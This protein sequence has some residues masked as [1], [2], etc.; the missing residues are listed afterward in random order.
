MTSQTAEVIALPSRRFPQ[1]LRSPAKR[2]TRSKARGQAGFQTGANFDQRQRSTRTFAKSARTFGGRPR[3]QRATGARGWNFDDA[4][5]WAQMYAAPEGLSHS[6]V[7]TADRN[8]MV[9]S[10]RAAVVR[11]LL[12]PAWDANSVIWKQ[13]TFAKG[14]HKH[15][16]ANPKKIERAIA[17]DQGLAGRSSDEANRQRRG[18]R[19]AARVQGGHAAACQGNSRVTRSFRRGD[20]AGSQA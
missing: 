13:T 10:W 16:D 8:S 1:G 19:K 6:D 14:Q 9:A 11:Q 20:Q 12:T 5:S 7:D 15:M 2:R 18:V 17:E 4:V 3:R